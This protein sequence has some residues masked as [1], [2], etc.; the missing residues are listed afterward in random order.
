MIWIDIICYTEK[1]EKK[2]KKRRNEMKWNKKLVKKLKYGKQKSTLV[3][4][5]ALS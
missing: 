1:K 3:V 2:E 4:V 5:K